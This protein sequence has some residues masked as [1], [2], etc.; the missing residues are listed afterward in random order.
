MV[1]SICTIC[2]PLFADG[3]DCA[4][5]VTAATAVPGAVASGIESESLQGFPG[6]TGGSLTRRAS[7]QTAS[8]R[9]GCI[10]A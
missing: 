8:L 6:P 9:P 4:R 3:G 7:V 2:T 5:V 10:M 1:I